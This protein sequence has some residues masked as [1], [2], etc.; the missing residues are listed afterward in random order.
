MA[1]K[2]SSGFCYPV[3][4]A[5]FC[6]ISGKLASH[7]KSLDT[8]YKLVLTRCLRAVRFSVVTASAFDSDEMARGANEL[9]DKDGR[10]LIVGK[11]QHA[12]GYGADIRHEGGSGMYRDPLEILG[13][14]IWALRWFRRDV[15]RS[16]GG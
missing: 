15:S 11:N 2:R 8:L 5:L 14:N 4:A 13:I 16:S 10:R 3:T 9:E 7:A 1:A 6:G 12:D